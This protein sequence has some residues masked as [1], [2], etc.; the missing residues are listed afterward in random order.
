MAFLQAAGEGCTGHWM[1]LQLG[2][3]YTKGAL[4]SWALS[5]DSNNFF[6]NPD[7]SAIQ[8]LSWSV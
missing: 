1:G 7:T 8:V 5:R 4:K 3:A 2:L 6:L